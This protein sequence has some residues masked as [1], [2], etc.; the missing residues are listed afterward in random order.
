[1]TTKEHIWPQKPEAYMSTSKPPTK[2]HKRH[3]RKKKERKERRLSFNLLLHPSFNLAL[4]N[5]NLASSTAFIE[6]LDVRIIDDA[7]P[8]NHPWYRHQGL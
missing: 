8:F 5:K 1:M 6:T 7:L 4:C 3:E 2:E